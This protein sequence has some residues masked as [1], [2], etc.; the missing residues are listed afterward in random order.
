[1]CEYCGCQALTAINELT[2]EHDLVIDLITEMRSALASGDL[3]VVPPLARQML[4]VLD[5]HTQVEERGLFPA[6]Q[7]EFPDHI[8]TLVAE[9]ECIE[10]VLKEALAG[11]PPDPNWPG[12]LSAM[13]RLLRQHILKEQDGVFPAALAS[14]TS[15]EWETVDQVRAQ[16][17]HSTAASRA[18]A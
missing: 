5:P 16:A 9:H 11:P 14:L 3:S 12:R 13:L 10:E 4:A 7:P 1:M 18:Q 8:E 2:R 15:A 17:G 6:L